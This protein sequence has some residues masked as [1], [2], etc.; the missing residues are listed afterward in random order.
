ML[1]EVHFNPHFKSCAIV[2]QFVSFFGI[3][4]VGFKISKKNC[5]SRKM[6]GILV[7]ER[8]CVCVCV[9]RSI[10]VVDV[11]K[12]PYSI[13]RHSESPDSYFWPIT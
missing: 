6:P 7:R 10:L 13:Q 1:G 9:F 4:Y 11:N 5:Q 2:K 8:L 12:S 3:I